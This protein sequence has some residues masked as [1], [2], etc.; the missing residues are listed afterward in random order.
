MKE[1]EILDILTGSGALLQGHFQLRSG[2]HSDRFFQAA[3]VL[4]F[5]DRAEA[6]C[7]SLAEFFRG[8][9]ID[10]VGQAIHFIEQAQNA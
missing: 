5:P 8:E 1:K 10:T 2:L 7:A 9:K 3:L 6:L 4:Q